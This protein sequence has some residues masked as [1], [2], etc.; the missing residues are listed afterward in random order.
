MPSLSSG[1]L[2]NGD[3]TMIDEPNPY[4]IESEMDVVC[5]VNIAPAKILLSRERVKKTM[6]KAIIR[7]GSVT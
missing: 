7:R 3:H 1:L 6:S 2:S 5:N 4:L